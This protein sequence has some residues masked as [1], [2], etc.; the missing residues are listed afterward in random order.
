LKSGKPIMPIL[1]RLKAQ[2]LKPVYNSIIIK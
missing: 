2:G 1:E